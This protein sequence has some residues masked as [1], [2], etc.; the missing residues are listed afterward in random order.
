MSSIKSLIQIPDLTALEVESVLTHAVDFLPQNLEKTLSTR[1]QS[2]GNH[3]VGLVFFESST[4]TRMSFEMAALR[5]GR[6]SILFDGSRGTSLE[7]GETFL[8]TLLNIA[9]MG[10]DILV[11]RAPDTLDM[12]DVSKKINI[13]ILNAGW[14]KLEHPSQALLDIFTIYEKRK[15]NLERRPERLLFVGD[16]KH[17]RVVG[18]HIQ[19]SRILNYEI[20]FCGPQNFIPLET[21]I[22]YFSSLEEGLAWSTSVMLLRV[23]KE[24]HES[25]SDLR[26]YISKYSLNDEHLKKL[27]KDQWILHPGPVNQGVEMN[28]NVYTDFRSLILDQVSHGVALRAALLD[29]FLENK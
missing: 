27:K 12:I 5:T 18:S 28:E 15:I 8:D 14:G 9:A 29:Y 19:L 1:T 25:S 11:I 3:V 17:S 26:E 13:P 7:K 4:R 21:D 24:R 2:S 16:V 20:A 10:P 22:P 6:K 23:Q